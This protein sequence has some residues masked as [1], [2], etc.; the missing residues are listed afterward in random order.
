MQYTILQVSSERHFKLLINIFI[1]HQRP[2]IHI[3]LVE[4][5][6]Y[7]TYTTYRKE[8]R[9]NDIRCTTIIVPSMLF[10]YRAVF[11]QLDII[12]PISLA[13]WLTSHLHMFLKR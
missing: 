13:S 10:P 6:T 7:S 1:K 8:K 2:H 11:K 5:I 9:Q 12:V 3:C 4:P